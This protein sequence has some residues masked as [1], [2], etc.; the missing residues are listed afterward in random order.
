MPY[1]VDHPARDSLSPKLKA[2][3][4]SLIN[5][6]ITTAPLMKQLDSIMPQFLTDIQ[7]PTYRISLPTSLA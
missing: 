3:S 6:A 4:E 2:S 1:N 7:Y 5:C